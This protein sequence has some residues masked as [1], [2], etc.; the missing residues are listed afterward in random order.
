M[1]STPTT[2]RVTGA[3]VV[4]ASP[5][6]A[7]TRRHSLYGIEDRVIIDPGSRIWKVGFSGEGKP[8]DVFCAN[9]RAGSALWNLSRAFD[10]QERAEEDRLLEFSLQ[11]CL[12]YV[13]HKYAAFSLSVI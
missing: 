13:F 1:P 12:R 4:H 11:R 8:R 3:P 7:T 6:Y 9:G 2:A 10:A 5:H